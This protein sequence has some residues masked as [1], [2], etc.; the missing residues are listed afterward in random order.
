MNLNDPGYS[1]LEQLVVVGDNEGE[2]IVLCGDRARGNCG[3]AGLITPSLQLMQTVGCN[4]VTYVEQTLFN[5][6]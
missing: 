5:R 6:K 4:D 2:R 1:C 3:A